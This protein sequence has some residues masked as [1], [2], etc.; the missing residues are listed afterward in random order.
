MLP[1]QMNKELLLLFGGPQVITCCNVSQGY[2]LCGG[3]EITL[4]HTFEMKPHAAST[5]H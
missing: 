2:H 4:L 5:L 3:G 1:F